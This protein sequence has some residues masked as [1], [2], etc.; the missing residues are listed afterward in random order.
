ME[1]RINQE[2][3]EKSNVKIELNILPF[4]SMSLKIREQ[5]PEIPNKEVSYIIPETTGFLSDFIAIGND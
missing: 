4:N 2:D 5:N 1:K 3:S